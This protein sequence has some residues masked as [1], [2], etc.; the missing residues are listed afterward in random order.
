VQCAGR[1]ELADGRIAFNLGGTAQMAFHEQPHAAPPKAI[2]G[3]IEQRFAGHRFFR[4]ADVRHDVLLGRP[5][6]TT[7]QSAQGQRCT[8]SVRNR[9]G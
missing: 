3:R 5:N 8:I 4:R 2:G 1:A 6:G 9:A 7:A